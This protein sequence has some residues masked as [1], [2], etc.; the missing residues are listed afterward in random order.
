MGPFRECAMINTHP[1]RAWPVT[2]EL[3]TASVIARS[4]LFMKPKIVLKRTI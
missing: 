4:L 3:N 2:S 1:E